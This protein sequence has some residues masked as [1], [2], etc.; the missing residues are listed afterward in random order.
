ML[1]G[2]Y[3]ADQGALT[4]F[5]A[6]TDGHIDFAAGW[7][8]NPENGD[9]T[10]HPSTILASNYMYFKFVWDDQKSSTDFGV[11]VCEDLTPYSGLHLNMSMPTGTDVYLTLTQKNAACTERTQDSAYVQLS[12]FHTPNGTPQS[13]VIPFS[14]FKYEFDNTTLYDFAHA[15]DAT[16]VNFSANQTYSFYHIGLVKNSASCAVAPSASTGVSGSVVA[17]AGTSVPAVTTKSGGGVVKAGL[18]VLAAVV[19]LLV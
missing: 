19:A 1:G 5:F 7:N 4:Y 11:T 9:P 8:P 16:F 6:P 14:Y 12:Q 15:K 17:P 10:L 2:D 3:G 13:F 18:S